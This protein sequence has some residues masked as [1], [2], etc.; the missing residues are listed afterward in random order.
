MPRFVLLRH[1]WPNAAQDARGSHWDL[2]LEDETILQTWA[3]NQIPNVGT[4]VDAESLPAHRLKY[5]DY[6]GP[7]SND[8]GEVSRWDHGN[9]DWLEK[10]ETRITVRLRGERIQGEA[11]LEQLSANHGWRFM[12][13]SK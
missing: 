8:R 5:L 10:T 7:V 4:W 9:F 6:E 1:E 12:V 2:M 3:I 13:A 11:V